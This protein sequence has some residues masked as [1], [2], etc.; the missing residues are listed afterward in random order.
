ML[1][2]FETYPE[3]GAV[4][5]EGVIECSRGVGAGPELN[6]VSGSEKVGVGLAAGDQRSVGEIA[7]GPVVGEAGAGTLSIHINAGARKVIETVVG[8]L[9]GESAVGATLDGGGPDAGGAGC[10]R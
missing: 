7:E 9:T 2:D 4:L 8:D 5:S 1:V 10:E 3:A 6:L